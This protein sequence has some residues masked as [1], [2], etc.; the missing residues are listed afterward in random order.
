MS[1]WF[2]GSQIAM[3]WVDYPAVSIDSTDESTLVTAECVKACLQTDLQEN[4]PAA[5]LPAGPNRKL[6][7]WRLPNHF[8][9][10]CSH[11]SFSLTNCGMNKMAD[12]LQITFPDAFSWIKNHC[13]LIKFSLKLLPMGTINNK[14]AWVQVMA[15][16]LFSTKPLP[17]PMLT[18]FYDIIWCQ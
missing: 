11:A 3:L 16:C 2:T 6:L 8:L 12:I 1:R 7:D 15:W 5:C 18:M 10:P 9:L 13:S 17:E 4:D 14:S